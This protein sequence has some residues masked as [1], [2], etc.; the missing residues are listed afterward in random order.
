MDR[1]ISRKL[2]PISAG[3]WN[4]VSVLFRINQLWGEQ[5]TGLK[6]CRKKQV[7]EGENYAYC[8]KKG[9]VIQIVSQEEKIEAYQKTSV[10]RRVMK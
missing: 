6:K 3:L 9:E 8:T 4:N 10:G 7:S 1:K 5:L 2:H